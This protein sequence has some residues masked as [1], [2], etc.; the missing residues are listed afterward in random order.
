MSRPRHRWWGY[1][2]NCIR[3]YPALCAAAEERGR[4][5][6]RLRFDDE[7]DRAA[8]ERAVAETLEKPDG[9][10]RMEIIR[11]VYWKKTHNMQGAALL[12]SV[13]YSTARRWHGQ[14]VCAVARN[15]K[16]TK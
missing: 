3:D 2:K 12:V 5:R 10:L 6:R 1:A 15:L 9:D 13:S 7:R 16:L 4:G 8:V 14:F 11:R